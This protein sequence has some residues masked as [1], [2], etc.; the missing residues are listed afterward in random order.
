MPVTSTQCKSVQLSVISG[1]AHTDENQISI[2]EIYTEIKQHRYM[3]NSLRKI[4]RP[5]LNTLESGDEDYSY[6]ESHRKILL[7]VGGLFLVLSV[8]SAAAAISTADKGG[9][10]AFLV[11]FLVG[12]LCEVVGLLGTNRAVAKLWGSK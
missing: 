11:F 9:L 5:V 1:Q 12:V 7:A 3:K 10:L 6:K 4:F 2:H 8:V